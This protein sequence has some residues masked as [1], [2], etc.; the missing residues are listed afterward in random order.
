MRRSE[1]PAWKD[2][3][4]RPYPRLA[5]NIEADVAIVGGGLAGV[6]SAY[7]LA[8]RG[9]KVAVLEA[10]TLGSGVTA[11]TTAFLTEVV[12]TDLGDLARMFGSRKAQLV[13]E[14]GQD[15][16]AAVE[17]IVKAEGIDCGF[18]RCPLYLYANADDEFRRL[19]SEY[20]IAK[21]LGFEVA[22]YRNGELGFPQ[23]GYLEVPRQAKFHPLKF[24]FAL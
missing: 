22:V 8:L 9:K 3:K 5:E 15:A 11:H 24:P 13:W 2:V 16:I 20:A 19:Q 14:S 21:E 12:D 17:E 6:A 18:M 4:R 10:E 1:E 23:R 7:L